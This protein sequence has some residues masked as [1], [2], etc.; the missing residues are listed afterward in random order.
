MF[1]EHDCFQLARLLPSQ[2]IPIGTVGVVLMV[3]EGTPRHYEV[4]FPDD[5]GRN[6]GT[7]PTFTIDE[8]FM[9]PLDDSA[10][11]RQEE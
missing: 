5:H 9:K 2:T 10:A 3:Y 7:E 6:L 8:E 11:G 4:E 1:N